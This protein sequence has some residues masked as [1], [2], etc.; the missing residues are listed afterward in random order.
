MNDK[1]L[2]RLSRLK[3]A[4]SNYE[5]TCIAEG[6]DN[7]N[8]VGCQ[9]KAADVIR[10]LDPSYN[11]KDLELLKGFGIASSGYFSHFLDAAKSQKL[12]SVYI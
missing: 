6:I 3:S 11:F 12:L 1:D 7:V 4:F 8:A 10:R 5:E 9:R 2:D